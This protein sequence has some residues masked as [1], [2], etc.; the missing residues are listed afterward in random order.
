MTAALGVR[1][2]PPTILPTGWITGPY[3]LSVVTSAFYANLIK[4]QYKH[5]NQWAFIIFQPGKVI[6]QLLLHVKHCRPSE[7]AFD[8][9]DILNPV[10]SED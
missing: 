10:F 9:T 1:Y 4:G 5:W 2:H 6:K 3:R 8:K 7:H